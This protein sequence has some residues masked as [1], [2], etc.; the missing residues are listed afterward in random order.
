MVSMLRSNR[1]TGKWI[2]HLLQAQHKL[3]NQTNPQS[4]HRGM[5]FP[6]SSP[7]QPLSTAAFLP[8]KPDAVRGPGVRVW[9]H[10]PRQ[11]ISRDYSRRTG[12]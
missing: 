8:N 11:K 3:L 12:L 6:L 4:S 5:V 10:T 1:F 9:P 2:S 7:Y